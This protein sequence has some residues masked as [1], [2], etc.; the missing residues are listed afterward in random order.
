MVGRRSTLLAL[1]FAIA[2]GAACVKRQTQGSSQVSGTCEGACQHYVS[3]KRS[4]DPR[5]L[6]ECVRDCATIYTDDNGVEDSETL[7]LFERLDCEE[8]ISFVEGETAQNN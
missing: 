3:C 2:F 7:G 1:A 6:R 8:T 5:V 4:D